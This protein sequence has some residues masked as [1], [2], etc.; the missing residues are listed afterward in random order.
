LF[1]QEPVC[2]NS[3]L[4]YLT[5]GEKMRNLLQLLP[6]AENDELNFIQG[7]LK[8]MSDEKVQQFAMIYNSRRKDPQTILLLTL[9]GFLGVAGIQRF[10][11][12]Q[13]GMGLL[14]VFTGG[15]CL[16]G[17]IVDIVNYKSLAFEYNQKVARQVAGMVSSN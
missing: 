14:Y 9:V 12:D 5:K 3:K 1:L 13:I 8:D 7:L 4:F 2:G 16:I 15:L 10:I 6:N 11:I 17:T